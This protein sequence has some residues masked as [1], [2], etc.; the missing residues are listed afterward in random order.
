MCRSPRPSR[1]LCSVRV[2]APASARGPFSACARRLRA[3]KGVLFCVATRLSTDTGCDRSPALEG[4]KMKSTCPAPLTACS[5]SRGGL[6]GWA[7]PVHSHLEHRCECPW[8][9]PFPS[10]AAHYYGRSTSRQERSPSRV[11]SVE[12]CP[13]HALRLPCSVCVLVWRTRAKREQRRL[14]YY[15]VPRIGPKQPQSETLCLE[16]SPSKRRLCGT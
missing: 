7:R 4:S 16:R 12:R 10:H 2:F 14:S 8:R 1:G 11:A 9:S 15:S 5:L 3:A 6:L 13:I